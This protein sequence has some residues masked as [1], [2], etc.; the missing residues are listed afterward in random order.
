M[1]LPIYVKGCEHDYFPVPGTIYQNLP[2]VLPDKVKGC[3]HN[4]KY[5]AKL[6]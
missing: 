5:L 4:A 1:L 6:Y 3:G 2:P